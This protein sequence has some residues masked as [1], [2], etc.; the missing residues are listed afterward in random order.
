MA[1]SVYAINSL[2]RFKFGNACLAIGVNAFDFQI[3]WLINYF[4]D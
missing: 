3:L 2:N 1:A 4:P